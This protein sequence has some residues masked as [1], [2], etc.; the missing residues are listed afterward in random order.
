MLKPLTAVLGLFVFL[1][2]LALGLYVARENSHAVAQDDHRTVHGII[3]GP[4]PCAWDVTLPERVMSEDDTQAVIVEAANE[5]GAECEST[6]SLRAPGFDT[7]PLKDEQKIALPLNGKGSLAWVLTP[8]KVGTYQLV[9]TDV[10][11][12]K[13]FGITVTNV[14]GLNATQMRLFTILGGLFGPIFTIPWWLDKWLQRRAKP[15]AEKA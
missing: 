13:V 14:F 12:T 4:P 3:I 10:L 2:A 1:A 5:A 9:V 6:V 7:S 11:N 15:K 8:R